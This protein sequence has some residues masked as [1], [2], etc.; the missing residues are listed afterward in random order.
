MEV[1]LAAKLA[2]VISAVLREWGHPVLQSPQSGAR[3]STPG[4]L[5][6]DKQERGK[7][8]KKKKKNRKRKKLVQC[9]R[10][11]GFGHAHTSCETPDPSCGICAD[12]HWTTHC[13]EQRK[14]HPGVEIPRRC[15]NCGNSGHSA[16]SYYCP[17]RKRY[18]R[19]NKPKDITAP[20]KPTM[21]DASTDTDAMKIECETA[22]YFGTHT[23][24]RTPDPTII[25]DILAAQERLTDL[26]FSDRLEYSD[27]YVY[28]TFKD[29]PDPPHPEVVPSHWHPVRHPVHEDIE[30]D[31][32]EEEEEPAEPL[33]DSGDPLGLKRTI[34]SSG[35]SDISEASS[36][37]PPRENLNKYFAD[38]DF[39]AKRAKRRKLEQEQ[40]DRAW[41]SSKAK[42]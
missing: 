41:N 33:P 40:R 29:L 39:K 31:E 25:D 32:A 3:G 17:E 34:A 19:G 11:Q 8:K 22:I 6:Q 7:G 37:S 28:W 21:V 2:S 16:P 10:C 42:S 9:R 4:D 14:K 15:T 36:S 20:T 1:A 5:G 30:E 13:I 12:H 24:S 38:R 27:R 35:P 26:V 23:D 18:L